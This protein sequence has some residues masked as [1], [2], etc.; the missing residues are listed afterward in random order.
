MTP[1][2]IVG[3]A[4]SHQSIFVYLIGTIIGG[5]VIAWFEKSVMAKLPKSVIVAIRFAALH[6]NVILKTYG[7]L[8]ATVPVTPQ[9]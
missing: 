6:W 8:E 2:D 4:C 9:K 1:A 3:Y 5:N 7:V